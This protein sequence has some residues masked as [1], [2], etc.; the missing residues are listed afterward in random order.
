MCG[1][2]YTDDLYQEYLQK[3]KDAGIDE[4]IA[5]YQDS[6]DKFMKK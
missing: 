2:F 1:G 4:Y 3:L 5:L 6:I